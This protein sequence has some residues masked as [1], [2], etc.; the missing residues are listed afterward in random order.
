MTRIFHVNGK[1][2]R[3]RVAYGKRKKT[4]TW[5]GNR[6]DHRS[7]RPPETPPIRLGFHREHPR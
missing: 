3:P 5:Q 1:P 4:R 6:L 7:P 2:I